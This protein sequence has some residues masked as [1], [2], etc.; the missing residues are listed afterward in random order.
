VGNNAFA[1]YLILALFFLC[2]GTLLRSS[3]TRRSSLKSSAPTR[4]QITTA[5]TPP[6]H[7]PGYEG[8]KTTSVMAHPLP[9]SASPAPGRN[10]V[11][12]RIVVGSDYLRNK[13]LSHRDSF[14]VG[15][16][17]EERVVERMQHV[18][19]GEWTIFR[20]VDLGSREGDIDVV[21]VGPGGIWAFEVKAYSVKYRV[22]DGSWFRE[23]S[24]GRTKKMPRGPGAQA[25]TNARSLCDYL[26]QHG[27]TRKNYVEPVV[28][29]S[30]EAPVEVVSA[31]TRIWMLED[32]DAQLA[33][34]NRDRRTSQ[35]HV[36]LVASVI[37]RACSTG[38]ELH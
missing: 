28:V 34:L 8:C 38:R 10:G 16:E 11:P 24:N 7:I 4:Q 32:L 18:L 3:R 33:F 2:S 1:I 25:L 22:K 27:V 13:S 31:G 29:M 35:D 30:G 26:K 17:G 37:E 19:N 12:P 36:R 5:S 21:L 23:Y 20:N 14:R 9:A 15:L 6:D